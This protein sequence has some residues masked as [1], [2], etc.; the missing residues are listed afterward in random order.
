MKKILINHNVT[1]KNVQ[2][3]LKLKHRVTSKRQ[4]KEKLNREMESEN[5]INTFDNHNTS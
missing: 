4:G 3:T 1:F 2:I 5:I